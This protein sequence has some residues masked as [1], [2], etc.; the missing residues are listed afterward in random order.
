[1]VHVAPAEADALDLDTLPV[2]P[3][4]P[5]PKAKAARAKAKKGAACKGAAKAKARTAARKMDGQRGEHHIVA[6]H[7]FGAIAEATPNKEEDGEDE[8]P[9]PAKRPR[10][11]ARKGA[12]KVKTKATGKQ[13]DGHKV[14][15]QTAAADAAAAA[16]AAAAASAAAAAAAAVAAAAPAAAVGSV[17]VE[18][19]SDVA[20]EAEG[21][22]DPTPAKRP[23]KEAVEPTRS[24]HR[25]AA[26]RDAGDGRVQVEVV[27][28]QCRRSKETTRQASLAGFFGKPRGTVAVIA[29]EPRAPFPAADDDEDDDAETKNSDAV[30]DLPSEPAPAL[31]SGCH[32]V[33]SHGVK[34]DGEGLAEALHCSRC[35]APMQDERFKS[36]NPSERSLKDTRCRFANALQRYKQQAAK[37]E[38]RWELTDS[39]A[40]ALMREVCVLCGHA[41]DLARNIPNGITRLRNNG[42][43]RSMG[44]YA[45]D[46][47]STACSACNMMK[48]THTLEEVRQIC[49]TIASH[50]CLGDFGRFPDVFSNNSSKPC[51]S[52]YLADHKT[53]A[54]TND[55]FNSI[56]QKPCHY[57]GKEYEKGKHY[58]G[59]DR[60]VNHVRIYTES[61]C[62]SCCGTCNTAKGSHSEELFLQKCKEIA[63]KTVA[64]GDAI[65]A[66]TGEEVA[67]PQQQQEEAA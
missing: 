17:A 43:L 31:M 62:V 20:E 55:Q 56:V 67:M 10:A 52:R 30:E 24:R 6:G 1:M 44:P 5:T 59:L 21:D 64:L 13:A 41:P 2:Q 40:L 61:T 38:A 28:M 32:A 18:T 11:A 19:T 53:H 8:D 45:I 58:N 65:A 42:G 12:A 27:C 57:C 49:R 7:G 35:L 63:E 23:R 4:T 16:A 34:K 39:Q 25:Q 15:K 54:L 51:R 46:N 33:F 36:L 50:R 3:C 26:E 9:T 29:A 48:G 47:V 37:T 14:D 66:S 22:K 60:L